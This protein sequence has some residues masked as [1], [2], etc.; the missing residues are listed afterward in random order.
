MLERA[1]SVRSRLRS[2]LF[3]DER[4]IGLWIL[5][6]FVMVA[7]MGA[8]LVGGLA[9]LYYGQQVAELEQTTR[10][11]RR[12]LDRVVSDVESTAEDAQRDIR[13][14][15]NQARD[16]FSRQA[17]IEGPNAK[18]IYAVSAQ[19]GPDETRVGSAFTVFS[20][21]T[22]TFLITTYAVVATDAGAALERVE[23]FLPNQQVTIRVH[24]FD[25][26]RDLAV[27]VAEGGPL[28]VLPWRPVDEPV[29]RG[30]A[31]YVVGI[32]G[33]ATPTV[34]SGRVAGVSDVAVVP[35]L[36]LNAFLA[37]GPLV[38]GSGRVVAIASQAYAPFG[39]VDGTL[40]YAP[41]IR[42]V[43]D[44]LIDCTAEDIGGAQDG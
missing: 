37:G 8:T 38:D 20:N 41:P 9:A 24:S 31:L 35:D 42:L 33:P 28:P 19:H 5:P 22:E 32:A 14:Q 29:R 7:L 3:G 10:Q 44:R 12:G 6:L 25:A 40:T 27:L 26:D 18:G 1:R 13:R 2:R 43:C 16:E 23:L 17:P 15:V 39:G 4:R 34:V 30:D 21:Q 11:A 36:P